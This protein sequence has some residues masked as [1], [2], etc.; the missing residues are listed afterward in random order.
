MLCD[1]QL[2]RQRI[3]GSSH[4]SLLQVAACCGHKLLLWIGLS[5]ASGGRNLEIRFLPAY[6]IH[7]NF[8]PGD[9]MS[10]AQTALTAQMLQ[11][12]ATGNHSYGEVLE[13]WKTSCP[14]L[15]V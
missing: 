10:K 7:D 14:R 12:I 5:Q 8:N 13:V 1:G 4:E 15:S 11:W 9:I 3:H 6:I 2:G